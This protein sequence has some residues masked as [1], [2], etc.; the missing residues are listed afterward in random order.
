M[1]EPQKDWPVVELTRRRDETGIWGIKREPNWS[2]PPGLETERY[3]PE[4]ALLSDEVIE[5]AT[6]AAL[7]VPHAERGDLSALNRTILSAAIKAASEQ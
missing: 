5:A 2:D 1:T 4:S 7:T 6:T 3:I